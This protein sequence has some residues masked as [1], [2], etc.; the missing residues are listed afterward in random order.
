MQ[1]TRDHEM[2]D[3]EELVVHLEN[4]PFPEAFHAGDSFANQI[5]EWRFDCA[6]QER[7]LESNFLER[8]PNDAS[9]ERLDVDGNV[10]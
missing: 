1:P 8:L 4:D 6:Q 7:R 9:T 2:E 5:S 10:G 3:D